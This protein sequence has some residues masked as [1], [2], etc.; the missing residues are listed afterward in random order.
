MSYLSQGSAAQF[1]ELKVQ[2][3]FVQLS[4]SAVVSI[5]AGSV[6]TIDCGQNIEVVRGAIFIDDSAATYAPVTAAN[7]SISG[8]TVTLTL[9]AAMTSADAIALYFVVQN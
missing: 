1:V 6:A 8:S 5:T 3:M 2:E 9:S 4:D 7:R